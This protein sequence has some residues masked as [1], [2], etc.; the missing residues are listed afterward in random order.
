MK[1]A[2]AA[3]VA[4]GS[5]VSFVPAP[6]AQESAA[7][8][9]PEE[10]V[11]IGTFHGPDSVLSAVNDRGQAVGLSGVTSVND[12]HALFWEDGR[13]VDLG[14]LPGDNVSRALGINDRRQ[15]VGTSGNLSTGRSR[16]VLWQ[17][18]QM[19]LLS[20]A[21]ASA[22]CEAT[23]V[24]HHGVIAGYCENAAVVWRD[25]EMVRIDVPG[26]FQAVAHAINDKGA[27]VG[28]SVDFALVQTGFLW[29]DGRVIE[30]A[31]SGHTM[32]PFDIN[33]RGQIVG[34]AEAFPGPNETEPVIWNDGRITPLSGTWAASMASH[35]A[36][37]TAAKSCCPDT[38]R[39]TRTEPSTVPTS[40]PTA[41]SGRSPARSRFRSTSTSTASPWA[42]CG[43]RL[44]SSA[45]S[46]GRLPSL[47]R[48]ATV[49][50]P[51]QPAVR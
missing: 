23:D 38:T 4:L 28:S 19:I 6:A 3:V 26:F 21:D 43:T 20:P 48:V 15:I 5:L 17:D 36:S 24:N 10:V 27:V 42:A 34:Y 49:P 50:D 39:R 41:S 46:S 1:L 44:A 32:V 14:V 11:I 30:L 7:G 12:W 25:G 47:D 16:A 2:C 31:D 8:R 33:K 51:L 45:A 9:R 40:G 37:T 13:M 29:K 22:D 18:G 35:G